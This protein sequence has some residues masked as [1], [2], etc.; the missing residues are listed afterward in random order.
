MR[1]VSLLCSFGVC[2]CV[3]VC[4]C[5]CRRTT[6]TQGGRLSFTSS[7]SSATQPPTTTMSTFGEVIFL[8][9]RLTPPSPPLTIDRQLNIERWHGH[10]RPRRASRS[11]QGSV[12]RHELIPKW[13]ERERNEREKIFGNTGSVLDQSIGNRKREWFMIESREYIS[14]QQRSDPRSIS[15]LS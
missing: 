11:L 14:G 8:C 3:R 5:V 15:R 6:H 2:T 1:S 4:V 10:S 9:A 12:F 7:Y 13:R